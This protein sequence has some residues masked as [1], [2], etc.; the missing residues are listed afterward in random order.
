M[1]EK[2]VGG[3]PGRF[4][5]LEHMSDVYVKAHGR[6]VIELFENSGLALFEAM[7]DTS[8][9]GRSVERIVE[10]E[11]FDLESLLYKWLENLL[12]LY[13][14]EKIMCSEVEVTEFKAEKK[15]AG[16]EYKVRGVC[17]GE[18]FNPLV[19]EARVEIKSPTYSLMRI[20]KDVD[21]W[22]AYFVLDI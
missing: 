16:E 20:L 13:Y 19:H 10:A 22:T 4:E 12:I 15:E 17:R 9:V 8:A 1:I 21:K 11:G 7:T 2:A 3:I 6:S 5:F 18:V 14:A